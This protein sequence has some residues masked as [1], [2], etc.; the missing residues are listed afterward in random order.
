MAPTKGQ[1]TLPFAPQKTTEN[2]SSSAA[3]SA[4]KGSIM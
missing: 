4:K 3:A 2:M 1:Q